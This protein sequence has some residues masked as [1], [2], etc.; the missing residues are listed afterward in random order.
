MRSL[1]RWI[2]AGAAAGVLLF[3]FAPASASVPADVTTVSPPPFEDGTVLVGFQPGTSLERKKAIETAAGASEVRTIGV[4]THVLHVA[5]GRVLSAI[6]ALKSHR[7]VRYAEP[8]YI[9]YADTLPNDPSFGQQWALRNTGQSIQGTDGT[10]GADIKA[11]PA[12][13]IATGTTEVVVGVV[14]TGMDYNQ[15]DLTA[16]IWSNPGG[17][18]GCPAGTHGYNAE[19]KTCDPKAV[20]R[21]HATMIASII[22]AA[23]NNGKGIAGVNWTTR[24]M[25]LKLLNEDCLCGTNENAIA[26]IDFAVKAK[27][28]GVNLRVLNNS[29]GCC[30]AGGGKFPYSDALL[31]EIKLAGAN[32][33]L[34]VA[35]AG[36]LSANNDADPHYPCS[37]SDPNAILTPGQT[38]ATN[39]ICVAATGQS[40]ELADFSN[41]G[42]NSVHLGAPGV[43]ILSA[44]I[45]PPSCDANG[46]YGYGEGTSMAVPHV[47]GA[48]ALVLSRGYQSVSTLRSTILDSVD[49]LSSLSGRVKTGGRLN[50]CKALGGCGASTAP[51]FSLSASPSSRT[52]VRGGSTSYTVTISSSGGFSDSVTLSVSGLPSGAGGSFSPNPATTS[53]STLS[54]TTS[55]TTPTGTSTLT[56]TGVSG[57]LTRSTTVTLSVKRK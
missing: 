22:G 19:S 13:S 16:N 34:F 6:A 33:I 41:F 12:W 4:G 51:D 54:V 46:S 21:H 45:C 1:G 15:P 36:N 32:D 7:E 25:A 39:V 3:G 17:T 24:I 20:S 23:G 11:E 29:Y 49:P 35:S 48:A 50:V 30:H 28:A 9:V 40:D 53:S 18:G 5:K 31:D 8:N 44:L 55:P 56:I 43:N 2:G 27:Q 14:D 37:Y 38:A 42:V 57:S 26:A 47:V 52:V 10:P